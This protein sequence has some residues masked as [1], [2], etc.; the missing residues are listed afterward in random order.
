MNFKLNT[1]YKYFF[2]PA[3]SPL[4]VCLFYSDC[5]LIHTNQ[6][7]S[8]RLLH[9]AN[10]H[11]LDFWFPFPGSLT[12]PTHGT[13][14]LCP[15]FPLHCR[16][17]WEQFFKPSS[18][19]LFF[20]CWQTAICFLK[21]PPCCSHSHQQRSV[22]SA[23]LAPFHLPTQKRKQLV[24][25]ATE[26]TPFRKSLFLKDL[27]GLLCQNLRVNEHFLKVTSSD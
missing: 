16:Q 23:S 22:T 9:I 6:E 17:S 11:F 24:K 12:F 19:G 21:I 10:K 5:L 27:W 25:S 15:S 7:P 4:S 20:H 13:G 1:S 18:E 14:Q 8:S 2:I 3:F 26:K